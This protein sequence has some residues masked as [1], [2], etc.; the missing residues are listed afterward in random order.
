MFVQSNWKDCWRK[1][2]VSLTTCL[3]ILS[4]TMLFFLNHFSNSLTCKG[5]N[6][7]PVTDT[8]HPDGLVQDCI[9]LV[10]CP[11][12][13]NQST[14][15]QSGQILVTQSYIRPAGCAASL[16][17]APFSLLQVNELSKLFHFKTEKLHSVALKGSIVSAWTKGPHHYFKINCNVMPQSIMGCFVL[18]YWFT[19]GWILAVYFYT[20]LNKLSRGSTEDD[21]V[22]AASN[23]RQ[24]GNKTLVALTNQ[25]K[26]R[27]VRGVG[28]KSKDR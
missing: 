19:F 12:P 26:K 9:T 24:T 10:P 22:R 15:V 21:T 8:A 20:D 2:I 17:G 3:S 13:S 27:R 18:C 1:K 5:G 14:H 7:A 23:K 16:A 4:D 6:G 11:A 25:P 28:R